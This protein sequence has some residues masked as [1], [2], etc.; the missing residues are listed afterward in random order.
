MS[1][2]A[3]LFLLLGLLAIPII[4]MY[5]LRL[6]RREVM[7]SSTMLWRQLMRD[8]EAN[9]PWQKLRRNLLLLLQLLILAALVLALAR[10]FLPIPSLV[11]QNVVVLLDGSASMLAGDVAPDRFRAAKAEAERLIADLGGTHQMTL[12]KAGQTPQVL[13]PATDD[14]GALRRALAAATA[15][16]A[17]ADWAAA[18]AL[19]AGAAQGYREARVVIISDG[20]LPDDLPP[21]PGETAFI[22]VGERPDN[23]A[24]AALATA[25]TP[26]QD[27]DAIQ[28]LAGVRNE[29]TQSRAALLSLTV[30]GTLFDARRITVPP[31][32]TINETWTLP[33]ETAVIEAHLSDNESDYLAADDRAWTVHGG[34]VSNRALLVTEGNRFLEQVYTVLPGVEAFKTGPGGDLTAQ[35]F[36][37]Y[38]FDSVPLPEQLPAA[39][40]FIINPQPGEA[41]ASDPEFPLQ[42]S[43]VFTNP[44]T[45]RVADSPL[46]TFVDWRNVH[47]R[48]ARQ[49]NAPWAQSLVAAEAGPLLLAGERDGR[50]WAILTFDLRESDL[51]L[52]IAFPVLIANITTWLSPGQAF[53]AAATVQPGDPVSLTPGGTTTAVTVQ[54]PDETTWT[55]EVGDAPLVFNETGQLGVY[56]VFL[57][58]ETGTRPGGR[59]A[60]NLFSPAESSIRPRPAPDFLAAAADTAVAEDVGQRELW[61][62]LLAA[63]IIVLGIEWWVHFRGA[64]LPALLRRQ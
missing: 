64:R 27:D 45:V 34:G 37:F 12:I 58:D 50:R 41:A 35:P 39:D 48:R 16:P 36:D 54:K 49:V 13:A 44:V 32:Q 31:G 63:A 62:W 18:F 6:R 21:L 60:V 23:L 4:V 5:M 10:P 7:V 59:F 25:V 30:D 1:F 17:P 46:L 14:K 11:N 51:P 42:V 40:L 26:G 20:G 22:S 3:P 29:G 2:L 24:I 9:A 28:L 55:A 52:Q 53:D 61:P 43:G 15:D 38:V 8:R 19:A 33:G 56:R 57:R 47:I